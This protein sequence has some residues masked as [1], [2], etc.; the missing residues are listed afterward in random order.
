MQ[1]KQM[2]NIISE[3]KQRNTERERGRERKAGLA[4]RVSGAD[5]SISF[6]LHHS[7]TLKREPLKPPHQWLLPLLL[8]PV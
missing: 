1:E 7:S 4:I 6:G 5:V 8:H 3:R 2:E